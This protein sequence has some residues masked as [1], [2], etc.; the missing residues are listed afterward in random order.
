MGTEL[1]SLGHFQLSP[2]YLPPADPDVAAFAL[3]SF[4]HGMVSLVIRERCI[5]IPNEQ[6]K[7]V[8]QGALDF[9]MT[10]KEVFR[11]TA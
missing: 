7:N 1:S 2:T 3:W 9:M 6:M 11:K 5:M 4:T 8:I 10:L